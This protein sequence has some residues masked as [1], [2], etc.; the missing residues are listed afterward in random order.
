MAPSTALLRARMA[1]G[2]YV[3]GHQNDYVIDMSTK[4]SEASQLLWHSKKCLCFVS[5]PNKIIIHAVI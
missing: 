1:E 2:I 5:A 4:T 3:I